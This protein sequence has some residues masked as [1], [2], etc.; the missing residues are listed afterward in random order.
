MRC[1]PPFLSAVAKYLSSALGIMGVTIRHSPV[2]VV[3]SGFAVV[4]ALNDFE[5]M[6]IETA[7]EVSH[8]AA[9]AH[10]AALTAAA[11]TGLIDLAPPPSP[12]SAFSAMVNFWDTTWSTN[13]QGTEESLNHVG[14]L[15]P[16]LSLWA[17][18]LTAMLA[19]DRVRDAVRPDQ[20]SASRRR[21]EKRMSED[22]SNWERRLAR[23]ECWYERSLIGRGLVPMKTANHA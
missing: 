20:A 2:K 17:A 10:G 16:I 1:L 6:A 14:L 5:A 3:T 7:R 19:S 22:A 8:A 12:P 18:I 23:L 11:S 13:D 4:L 21:E 15:G 9:A